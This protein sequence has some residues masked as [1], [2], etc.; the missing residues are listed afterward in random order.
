M[1][2]SE[3]LEF[4]ENMKLF[5]TNFINEEAESPDVKDA[6]APAQ[7]SHSTRRQQRKGRIDEKEESVKE[8]SQPKPRHNYEAGTGTKDH[9]DAEKK[10]RVKSFRIN[11]NDIPDMEPEPKTKAS[12][13]KDYPR[14]DPRKRVVPGSDGLENDDTGIP[15][16]DFTA[17]DPLMGRF[18]KE[19]SS[20]SSRNA[21]DGASFMA[22]TL[23]TVSY[24]HLTLLTI[25]R[26]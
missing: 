3:R 21:D 12:Q 24:T 23:E 11:L 13:Y 18:S 8:S 2:E 14:Y 17:E 10:K 4:L 25:L 16:I 6:A 5:K 7:D 22:Q 15:R 26:V 19:K 9:Q 20:S 1:S